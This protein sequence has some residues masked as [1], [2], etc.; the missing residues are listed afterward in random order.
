MK[1]HL[2]KFVWGQ[3]T[4]LGFVAVLSSVSLG[5]QFV[6]VSTQVGLI[7]KAKKS[8]GNPIW[9][10][11]INDGV[12]DLIV[13]CHGLLSWHGP[14]LYLTNAWSHFNAIRLLYDMKESSP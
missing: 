13:Q 10:D 6:D 4:F 7:A 5:Q 2:K 3:V 8:W 14:F 9:S 12:L 11:I 1:F